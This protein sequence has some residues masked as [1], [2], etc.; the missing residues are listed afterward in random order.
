MNANSTASSTI[1]HDKEEGSI[2]GEIKLLL[3]RKVAGKENPSVDRERSAAIRAWEGRREWRARRR[4]ERRKV[5]L[6]DRTALLRM[7]LDPEVGFGDSYM[8][9]RAEVDGDLVRC[10]EDVIRS[11]RS[12]AGGDLVREDDFALAGLGAGEY[13]ARVG[14]KYSYALRSDI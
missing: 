9:G 12:A 7:L 1:E 5:I 4:S 6:R 10:L 2:R 8:E 13:A 3:S 11:M 14:E